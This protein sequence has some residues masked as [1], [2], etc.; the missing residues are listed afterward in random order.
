MAYFI[1]FSVTLP[2]QRVV[3]TSKETEAQIDL[4]A[5]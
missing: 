3:I 1:Y 2:K 5:I 4:K